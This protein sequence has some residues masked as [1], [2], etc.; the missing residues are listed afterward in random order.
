ME[1]QNERIHL[2]ARETRAKRGEFAR[3]TSK[4]MP[5]SL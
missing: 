3:F 5:L 4:I 2:P 1:T